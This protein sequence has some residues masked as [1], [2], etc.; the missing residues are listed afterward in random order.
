MKL[1]FKAGYKYFYTTKK[2]NMMY[3]KTFLY[4]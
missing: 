2:K 3:V 1:A 4:Y